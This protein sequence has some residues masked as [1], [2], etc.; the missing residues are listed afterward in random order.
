[1]PNFL[2]YAALLIRLPGSQPQ[3]MRQGQSVFIY[4]ANDMVKCCE[5][6]E[7]I[8]AKN[9]TKNLSITYRH[10]HAHTQAHT[11][12]RTHTHAHA[13]KHTCT[14]THPC[15]YTQTSAH[16]HVPT[17]ITALKRDVRTK[18]PRDVKPWHTTEGR[19][20]SL[21]YPPYE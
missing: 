12:A 14:H 2:D 10:A 6:K 9:Q 8:P 15:T 5:L 18:S 16:M 4:L 17:Q 21:L 7:A 13:R 3:Q 11:H 1:M 20:G 19:C